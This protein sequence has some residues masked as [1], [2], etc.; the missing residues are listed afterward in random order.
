MS[1]LASQIANHW[2][3]PNK[4]D[5]M[6]IYLEHNNV[7]Q[8]VEICPKK[9]QEKKRQRNEEVKGGVAKQLSLT[10]SSSNRS[11]QPFPPSASVAK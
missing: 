11:V 8:E 3:R 6:D 1:D 10:A 2:E 5:D 7:L 9:V 4:G